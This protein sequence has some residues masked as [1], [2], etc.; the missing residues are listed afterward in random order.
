[1]AQTPE[2]VAAGQP[3]DAVPPNVAV[4]PAEAQH[5]QRTAELH[6]AELYHG[7]FPQLGVEFVRRWHRVH[8][9]SPYGVVFVAVRSGAVIGF[10]LGT[11]DHR[12]HVAWTIQNHRRELL[13]AAARAMIARPGVM[14]GF[15]RTR[16]LRY[17]QRL[18]RRSRRSAAVSRGA[19]PDGPVAV[20]EAIVVVP[21]AQGAGAGRVLVETFLTFAARAG[22][23]RVDLVTK[24]GPSGAAG[25][26]RRS[27]WQ[28]AGEHVDRD[29]ELALTFRIDPSPWHPGPSGSS[30]T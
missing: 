14:I 12:R 18:L 29:G 30:P 22:V 24:A 7:L 15:L 2:D 5:L 17:T 26:Y 19:G 21:S 10:L 3:L 25:F 20:L 8:C 9:Y 27:G 4:V 6:V 23:R 28:P 11:T 16:A 1:M 13:L